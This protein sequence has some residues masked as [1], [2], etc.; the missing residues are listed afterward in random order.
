MDVCV[1]RRLNNRQRL[2]S[3][4]QLETMNVD[5]ATKVRPASIRNNANTADVEEDERE[6]LVNIRARRAFEVEENCI[7]PAGMSDLR[8]GVNAYPSCP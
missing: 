2:T 5:R 6:M 8:E 7:R 1:E 4:S 3:S